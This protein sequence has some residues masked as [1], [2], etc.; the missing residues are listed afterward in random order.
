MKKYILILFLPLLFACKVIKPET[1]YTETDNTEIRYEM[2]D[3]TVKGAKVGTSVNLD[4]LYKVAESLR[5]TWQADSTKAAQNGK[6][7]PPKPKPET[8]Y[9]TDPQTKAQL[10]YWIDEYGKLQI[11][12]ESKSQTIS[13]LMAQVKKLTAQVSKRTEVVYKTPNWAYAVMA[14]LFTLLIISNIKK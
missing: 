3:V 5:K 14:V 4:S 13:L 11:G 2:Q 1:T 8:K 6:P 7:L 12:C 9:L 10:S